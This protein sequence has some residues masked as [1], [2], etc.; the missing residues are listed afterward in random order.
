MWEAR[1]RFAGTYDAAW[2]AQ[3]REDAARGL[4]PDYPAD[5]DARFFQCAHPA[6][7]SARPLG[8][9]EVF[10]LRGLSAETPELTFQLPPIRLHAEALGHTFGQRDLPAPQ[11]DLVHVDLDAGRVH[12]TFRL[13]LHPRE[14]VAV[15]V[16]RAHEEKAPC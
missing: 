16:L 6:L 10:S 12:A 14:E 1:L 13:Q 11:L 8:G 5:L 2:E 7:C 15:V 9:D 3:L 4:L